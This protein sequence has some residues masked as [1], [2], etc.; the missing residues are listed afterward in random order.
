MFFNESRGYHDLFVKLHAVNT[1]RWQTQMLR[2][3]A[4]CFD[5]SIT[6]YTLDDIRSFPISG[7]S[8]VGTHVDDEC[9]NDERA[10]EGTARSRLQPTDDYPAHLF[11]QTESSLDVEF[12]ANRQH[13]RSRER[14]V[15]QLRQY[16]F[17]CQGNNKNHGLSGLYC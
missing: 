5:L 1:S 6:V 10:I 17:V 9:A 2:S 16:H 14:R 11:D 3:E 12:V 4:L 8:L 15:E 13:Q 7:R